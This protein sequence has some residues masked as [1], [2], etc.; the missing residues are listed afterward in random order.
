MSGSKLQV[1]ALTF[2]ICAL[3]SLYLPGIAVDLINEHS[4]IDIYPSKLRDHAPLAL[5]RLN[6]LPRFMLLNKIDRYD[7]EMFSSCFNLLQERFTRQR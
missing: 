3:S 1:Q 5:K 4:T 2:K 7:M 6:D